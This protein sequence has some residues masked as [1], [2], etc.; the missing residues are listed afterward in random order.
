MVVGGAKRVAA[1]CRGWQWAW[2]G[3]LGGLS[4]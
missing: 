3:T 2:L 1:A 4:S